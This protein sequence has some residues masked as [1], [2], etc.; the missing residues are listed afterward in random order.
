MRSVRFRAILALTALAAAALA[1]C[2]G[3]PGSPAVPSSLTPSPEAAA[4]NPSAVPSPQP[5]PPA[6]TGAT[7]G[8]DRT[9]TPSPAPTAAARG[10]ESAAVPAAPSPTPTTVPTATPT[11][12]STPTTAPTATPAF[13]APDGVYAAITVG[14][15]DACGLTEEGEAV[16]WSIESG[17]QSEAPSGRYTDIT[18]NA[19]TACAITIEGEIMCWPLSGGPASADDYDWLDPSRGAPPDRYTAINWERGYA[20]ALTEAGEVACWGNRE[21]GPGYEERVPPD[22]PP[23]TYTAIRVRGL[24]LDYGASGVAACALAD[25][26][27]VACW[28]YVQAHGHL[29]DSFAAIYLGEYTTT[30]IP[31]ASLGYSPHPALTGRPFCAVTHEG[32]AE[33][34]GLSPDL[35]TANRF[36]AVS[37]GGT[38]ACAVT[39]SGAAVCEVT[40]TRFDG[41]DRGV[42]ERLGTPPDPSPERF[43]DVSLGGGGAC[44][45]TDTGRVS[46]WRYAP[47]WV[48]RPEPDP[49]YVA[50]S[51]GLGHTCALTEAGEAVCWGWN[52][53]G[54]A[55][56][57]PGRYTAISAGHSRTC[58]LTG[59]GEAVCW[60]GGSSSP[61]TDRLRGPITALGDGGACVIG[62]GDIVRPASGASCWPQT[63]YGLMAES[64]GPFVSFSRD[65][66]GH[67]CALTRA[68]DAVCVA[69]AISPPCA[70]GSES[71]GRCGARVGGAPPGAYSMVRV[72]GHETCGVTSEGAITCWDGASGWT[73]D[74]PP[75]EY[76][77]VSVG[78]LHG[79]ALTEAG[80]ANCWGA[81]GN[82]KAV[83]Y[84]PVDPPPGRYTAI[85]SGFARSCALTDAGEV[86]CWGDTGYAELPVL[87]YDLDH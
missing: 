53:F 63:G 21:P 84:G 55:Q 9:E 3:G 27:D 70:G 64:Q 4:P 39:L 54:Q 19:D 67:M 17:G 26:G 15:R 7:R 80:E 45:L 57:P 32:A 74:I 58:A 51:D 13:D 69:P 78:L 76:V 77:E 52:N 87:Y 65:M 44:A 43:V 34:C 42:T 6:A 20:C 28:G 48:S 24:Y 16:C 72:G 5:T 75:D 22:P 71:G 2:D 46:C 61:R 60:G 14:W 37:L 59:A 86:I 23:G 25:T 50:V 38:H 8:Q 40:R 82:T 73:P 83:V 47:S 41:V 11:A 49:V 79:C 85:S 31:Q 56:A 10:A 30:P 18:A 29:V 33:G 1:A 12:S 66:N 36:A 68:G 35:T 62:D 81:M